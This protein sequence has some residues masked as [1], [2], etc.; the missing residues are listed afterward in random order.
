MM[1]ASRSYW[2]RRRRFERNDRPRWSDIPEEAEIS[3]DDD[4]LTEDYDRLGMMMKID[5]M[6]R[7]WR[8]LVNEHGFTPV[9]NAM[10]R[11]NDVAAVKGSLELRRERR[12]LD[13]AYPGSFDNSRMM[14]VSF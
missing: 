11:T 8:D 13:Y 1:R 10:A 3:F 14:E 6:P 7:V 4:D 12:Q 5:A 9:I 2:R